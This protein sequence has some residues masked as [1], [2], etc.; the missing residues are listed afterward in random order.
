MSDGLGTTFIF[1][2]ADDFLIAEKA[3]R[4]LCLNCFW[5]ELYCMYH[6]AHNTSCCALPN[7]NYSGR[8]SKT[9][10]SVQFLHVVKL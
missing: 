10:A 1:V 2:L 7:E 9:L 8:S 3:G 4:V 6:I 5:R